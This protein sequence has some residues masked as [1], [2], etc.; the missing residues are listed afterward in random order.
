MIWQTL[1][2]VR[3]L[4]VLA[5]TTFTLIAPALAHG[6]DVFP[7]VA[8]A[9]RA[10]QTLCF[11]ALQVI[12]MSPAP[13]GHHK[14]SV[15]RIVADELQDGRRVRMTYRLP[16]PAAG[17]VVVDDGHWMHQWEP[18][19]HLILLER[20]RTESAAA[21]RRM[22]AL[23]HR[24]YHCQKVSTTFL[25][26][27]MCD[28]IQISPRQG[29]SGPSRL[30]W[31]ERRHHALLKT[32]EFDTDGVRRYVS[33][34]ERFRFIRTPSVRMFAL[35]SGIRVCRVPQV[36]QD[37]PTF[38]AAKATAKLPGRLPASL[39]A[40]YSLLGCAAARAGH[41]L[42]LRYSDGLEMLSVLESP[43]S[44]GHQTTAPAHAG[45]QTWGRD[46]PLLHVAVMGD[47]TLPQGLG[48]QM[49]M[50]LEPHKTPPHRIAPTA[51]HR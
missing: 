7:L 37:Q 18:S 27:L 26:G 6:A 10:R 24:N 3:P 8:Q 45:Q 2:V 43:V 35:P 31:I 33:F 34:F 40:G 49:L 21:Q 32:E 50:A 13:V 14:D 44:A 46:L 22:L 4:F 36:L 28:V 39:P 29:H 41:C 17:R 47:D 19:R 11:R 42:V 1:K 38:E 48:Q 16:V 23:L 25:H 30:L 5:F 51:K 12:Q 20:S 9:V 15:V